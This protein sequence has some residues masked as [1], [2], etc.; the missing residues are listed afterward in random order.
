MDNTKFWLEVVQ[1]PNGKTIAN[2]EEG[3]PSREEVATKL[4][5]MNVATHGMM[6]Q[7]KES[8]AATKH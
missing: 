2:D 6:E 5:K 7:S 3:D 4:T 8:E 1:L